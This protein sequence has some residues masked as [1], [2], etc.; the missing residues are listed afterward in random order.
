M[1]RLVRL[2]TQELQAARS[3]GSVG[4]LAEFTNGALVQWA[5]DPDNPGAD[6]GPLM[7]VEVLSPKR[8]K[9]RD[10]A[11]LT[12]VGWDKPRGRDMPNWWHL[13]G[14][15]HEASLVAGQLVVLLQ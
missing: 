14:D 3:D 1:V 7:I 10:R 8:L 5:V 13:V 9:R 6:D 2:L 4:V 12:E 11:R 15:D